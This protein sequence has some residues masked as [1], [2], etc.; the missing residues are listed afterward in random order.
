M[1]TRGTIIIAARSLALQLR[2]DIA[3]TPTGFRYFRELYNVVFIN[4]DMLIR[5]VSAF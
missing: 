5:A 1:S 4:H 3:M 2:K